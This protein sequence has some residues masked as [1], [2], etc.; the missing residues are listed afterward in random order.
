ME[1]DGADAYAFFTADEIFINREKKKARELRDTAWW[2]KKKSN[3]V[4][5]YCRKKFHPSELTM[6]HV[7]PIVRGG[8]SVKEN[9]VPC[10]KE[11]NNKKKYLLPVEWT[12]YLNS[13][14][15]G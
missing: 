5:H 11:C 12:E 2:K 9:L 1:P 10:C 15:G 4:C 8:K 3:G 13:L 14:S 7:I 6:D